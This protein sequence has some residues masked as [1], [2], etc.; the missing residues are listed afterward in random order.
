[1]GSRSSGVTPCTMTVRAERPRD[2]RERTVP[3]GAPV[4]FAVSSKLSTE[5]DQ[6]SGA[7]AGLRFGASAEHQCRCH[8]DCAAAVV[9]P[10]IESVTDVPTHYLC[11]L[12]LLIT[13]MY[14]DDGM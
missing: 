14:W 10:A 6:S 7:F 13:N 1:M 12:T 5:R 2:T 11:K 3:T 9:S 4:I 8:D